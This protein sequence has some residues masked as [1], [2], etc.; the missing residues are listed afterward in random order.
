MLCVDVCLLNK[1]A[2]SIISVADLFLPLCPSGRPAVVTVVCKQV[3]A[4]CSVLSVLERGTRIHLLFTVYLGGDPQK[5][6]PT[7]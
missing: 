2:G 7:V 4:L 6:L 5:V 1:H 3:L